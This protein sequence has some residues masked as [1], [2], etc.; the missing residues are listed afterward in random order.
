MNSLR[1]VFAAKMADEV[2][3]T[4]V[5]AHAPVVVEPFVV[6]T[7]AVSVDSAAVEASFAVSP[8]V[9]AKR[10][11]FTPGTAVAAGAV[12]KLVTAVVPRATPATACKSWFNAP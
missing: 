8:V 7:K 6:T 9:P 2:E 12:P 4:A 5:L 1:A 3:V 10:E 11:A